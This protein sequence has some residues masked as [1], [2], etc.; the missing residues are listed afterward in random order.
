M[1]A[2][3][4]KGVH[5]CS[6]PDYPGEASSANDRFSEYSGTSSSALM[7]TSFAWWH[8]TIWQHRTLHGAGAAR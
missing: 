6:F 4:F 8:R 1:Q 7:R 3:G 5:H 2:T